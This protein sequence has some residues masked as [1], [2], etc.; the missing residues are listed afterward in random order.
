MSTKGSARSDAQ[1][2]EL[3]GSSGCVCHLGAQLRPLN[4]SVDLT[5]GLFMWLRVSCSMGTGVWKQVLQETGCGCRLEKG[6]VN[7]PLHCIVQS[8]W[9]THPESR[10]V[11]IDSTS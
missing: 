11:D 8:S 6:T 2:A 5:H 3:W 10:D 4:L 9:K 7:L 1:G